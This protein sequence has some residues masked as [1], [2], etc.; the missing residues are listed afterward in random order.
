MILLKLKTVGIELWK[1]CKENPLFFFFDMNERK[2]SKQ[3][4]TMID[5]EDKK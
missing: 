5:I 2:T 3:I 4:D 1:N